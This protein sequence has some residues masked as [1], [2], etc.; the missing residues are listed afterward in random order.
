MSELLGTAWA[1]PV[2]G[3]VMAVVGYVWLRHNARE[4]D[5]KYGGR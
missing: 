4:F 3:L 5:R 1:L 2:G